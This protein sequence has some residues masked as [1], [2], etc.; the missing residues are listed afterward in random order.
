MFVRR[1]SLCSFPVNNK[2]QKKFLLLL[3][4]YNKYGGESILLYKEVTHDYYKLHLLFNIILSK[5]TTPAIWRRAYFTVQGSN[6][7]TINSLII[8]LMDTNHNKN[9]RDKQLSLYNIG[10]RVAL[11]NP[12]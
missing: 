3:V 8:V 9:K 12:C 4:L 5:T 1:L 2:K 10:E 6:M 11:L 7:I